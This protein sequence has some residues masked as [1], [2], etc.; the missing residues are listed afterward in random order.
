MDGVIAD[1]HVMPGEVIGP[2]KVM[3]EIVDPA[4]LR[5]EAVIHDLTLA[6][7]VTAASATSRLL[8][9]TV[10]GLDLL[11][12][13][14]R[15]DLVD[16]GIHAIFVPSARQ[17]QGLRIGMPVDVHLSVGAMRLK[18]AVPRQA[19]VDHGGA[20]VVFIRTGPES[21]EIRPVKLLRSLGAWAEIDGVAVGDKVVVQ[22]MDQLRG[23]R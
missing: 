8:P 4:R 16:Q 5:I 17:A 21:F 6:D 20:K 2:D 15:V 7:T 10:Y 19:V 22:G 11:G 9:D 12:I 14:P 1:L 3:V 18:L 23:A 13:S